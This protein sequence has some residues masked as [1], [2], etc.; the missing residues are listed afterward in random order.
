MRSFLSRH[1]HKLTHIPTTTNPPTNKDLT[2]TTTT[3]TTTAA[4]SLSLSVSHTHIVRYTRTSRLPPSPT[5]SNHSLQARAQELNARMQGQASVVFD[6]I[7]RQSLR[8]IARGSYACVLKC[9]DKAG[10]TGSSE[11]LQNCSQNCQVPYQN[12]NAIVQNVSHHNVYLHSFIHSS[13]N[14]SFWSSVYDNHTKTHKHFTFLPR[15][16]PILSRFVFIIHHFV[17]SDRRRTNS[18]VV[19]IVPWPIVKTEPV[20]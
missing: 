10:T 17:H 18:R 6:E 16:N 13:P 8:K 11:M 14:V 4:V 12:A 2:T 19:L 1:T 3:T 15:S 5:M 9:F 7:D 20:T